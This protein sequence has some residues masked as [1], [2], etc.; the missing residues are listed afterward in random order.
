MT[1]VIAA[2]DDSLAARP[3]LATALALAPLLDADV[4]PVHADL[5]LDGDRDRNRLEDGHL[6]ERRRAH[7]Q[8]RLHRH[9]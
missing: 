1:K 5:L 6:D 8:R 4:E 2:L 9:S 3:V 7:E